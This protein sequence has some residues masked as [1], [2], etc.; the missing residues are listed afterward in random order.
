MAARC[1]EAQGLPDRL[2]APGVDGRRH[3]SVIDEVMRGS[4]TCWASRPSCA[5]GGSH[6]RSRRRRARPGAGGLRRGPDPVRALGGY[7]LEAEARRILAGLGFAADDMDRPFTEMSGG[8]R[9]RA[10]LARLLL[11]QPTCWCSTSPPTTSTPTRSPGSSSTLRRLPGRR[12]VRQ[13][14]PRLHRR[15]R[16]PRRR[17]RLRNG[18]RSTSA[19]SPSSSCSARSGSPASRPPPRQPASGGRPG[20]AVRRAVPLQGDQ[21]PP[22]AEPDQD[23]REAGADRGA[24]PAGELVARFGFPEPRRSSRVV[25]EIDD[26]DR[27]LR[28]RGRAHRRRPGGRAGPASWPL[29]GPERRRQVDAAAGCSWASCSR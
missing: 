11:P 3:G 6:R 29:V 12:P 15:R 20:R 23:A 25:V 26:V 5:A 7:A 4:V 22:G 21:G 17:A 24:R 19:A 28:R 18:R 1:I 14:R 2:P 10:A 8:W 27:R 16:R 9:M 13:P